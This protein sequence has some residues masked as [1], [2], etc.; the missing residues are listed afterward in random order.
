MAGQQSANTLLPM[1]N[2]HSAGISQQ[3]ATPG[4]LQRCGCAWM[5]VLVMRL[6][7]VHCLHVVLV[8]AM[9]AKVGALGGVQSPREAQQ[10][11]TLSP[12]ACALGL[13]VPCPCWVMLPSGVPAAG[14]GGPTASIKSDCMLL[15]LLAGAQA[16]SEMGLVHMP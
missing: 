3:H 16:F 8:A 14:T 6:M 13:A 11:S 10:H 12:V 7:R 5:G 4:L 1:D 15:L 9:R 2:T